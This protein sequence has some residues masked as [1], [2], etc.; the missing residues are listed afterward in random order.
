[1]EIQDMPNPRS[2]SAKGK[3]G[4]KGGERISSP[5]RVAGQDKA[6]Q[7]IQLRIAGA[8][9]ETIAETVGY[10]DA[11]SAWKAVMRTLQAAVREPAKELIELEVKRLDSLFLVTFPMAKQGIMGAVDRCLRIM[12]RRARLLGLDAPIALSVDWRE[13][14][15]AAGLSPSEEFEALVARIISDNAQRLGELPSGESDGG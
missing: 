2:P 11:G 5:R 7:A 8:Q 4:R 1:M 6:R 12:E 15:K 9:F 14:A 13:E 3:R 10:A